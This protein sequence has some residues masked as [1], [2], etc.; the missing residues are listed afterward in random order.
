MAGAASGVITVVVM[1][2]SVIEVSVTGA[3]GTGGEV[4]GKISTM[5]VG[6][7]PEV[8]GDI[9]VPDVV[10]PPQAA[11][12]SGTNRSKTASSQIR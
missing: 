6:G 7:G 9:V 1:V 5:V 3:V 8:V 10:V 4:G 12:T 11:S 2:E